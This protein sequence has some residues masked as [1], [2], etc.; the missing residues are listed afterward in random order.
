MDEAIRLDPTNAFGYSLRGRCLRET[1]KPD[2]AL[3]ELDRAIELAVDDADRWF[4]RGI[5]NF[6]RG[7][8]RKAGTDLRTAIRLGVDISEWNVG[9]A[10]EAATP[11]ERF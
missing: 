7:N 6:E 9:L 5:A 1:G 8:Y 3:A 11:Y 4:D 10:D 2:Q